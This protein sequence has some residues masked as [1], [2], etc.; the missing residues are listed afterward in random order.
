MRPTWAEV[1]LATLR[2]NYRII[3]QHVGEAVTVCP[4]VKAD[5][6]GHGAVECARALAAEGAAWFGV[7]CTEEGIALREA[8]IDGR[9]LLMTGFWRGDEQDVIRHRLTPAVWEWWQ[10]GGL[11]AGLNKAGD[12][13]QRPFPV[14]VKVDTGMARLGVPDYF[15]GLFLRRLKAAKDV[16][17]EGLFSHLASAEVIDAPDVEAQTKLFAEFEEFAR[18]NGF[19]PKYIHIANS[20]AVAS[21][22]TLWRDLVRPGLSLY[23]YY[24]PFTSSD[25][26]SLRTEHALPVEPVLSWKARV[27]SM[28]DIGEGHAVGYGGTF[29]AKRKTKLATLPVGY[30]DGLNRKLSSPPDSYSGPRGR[31]I[32]RGRYAAI[33]GR[34]SMDVTL[35]DVTDIDGV[36]VGDEVTI[37]GSQG[38]R[39]ISAQEHAEIVGT[40]PYEILC[41]I[42]KR[43]PRKYSE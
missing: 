2:H 23:G 10:V 7:T 32:V 21:R 11:E 3:K 38:E 13:A 40:V 33:A 19:H 6:Y 43:V 42:G 36:S 15:M 18:Q 20:A 14:H 17:V 5:A 22:S 28:R 4:V 8:G 29:V 24:L 12:Q 34:V 16:E 9:I 30:A 39:S 35:L 41:A 25:D 31:M 27:I 1:S 37:L 26:G